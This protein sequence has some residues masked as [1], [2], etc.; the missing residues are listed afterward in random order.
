[1]ALQ[2]PANNPRL[3]PEGSGHNRRLTTGLTYVIVVPLRNATAALATHAHCTPDCRHTCQGRVAP[4]RMRHAAAPC[5]KH[6]IQPPNRYAQALTLGQLFKSLPGALSSPRA[7]RR[8]VL[9]DHLVVRPAADLAVLAVRVIVRHA[10]GVQGIARDGAAQYI[11]ARTR[12]HECKR[13]AWEPFTHA[14]TKGSAASY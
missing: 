7:A 11:N 13:A 4:G 1:M 5:R 14:V 10:C 3:Q 6:P 9:E 2:V 8:R 12:S